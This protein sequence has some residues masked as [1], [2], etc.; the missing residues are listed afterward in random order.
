MGDYYD[1]LLRGVEIEYQSNPYLVWDELKRGD[2]L[3]IQ[4]LSSRM[5][6]G[7]NYYNRFTN[8][9]AIDFVYSLNTD[10][11]YPGQGFEH[12][13]MVERWANVREVKQI[14]NNID[15]LTWLERH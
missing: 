12:P 1:K 2:L 7:A 4:L 14:N 11:F 3:F 8:R 5:L 13:D 15:Y 10:T 9:I 6:V